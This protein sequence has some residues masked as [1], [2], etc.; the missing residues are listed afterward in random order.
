MNLRKGKF[1]N[2]ELRMSYVCNGGAIISKTAIQNLI[3]K[4]F[5]T[6]LDKELDSAHRHSGAHPL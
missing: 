2:E 6:T 1:S 5:K 3:S 4:T